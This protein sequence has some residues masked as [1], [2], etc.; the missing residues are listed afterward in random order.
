MKALGVGEAGGVGVHSRDRL[1][2]QKG[3][4]CHLGFAWAGE[5][6]NR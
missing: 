3:R 1:D 6:D 5:L 2:L 4:E